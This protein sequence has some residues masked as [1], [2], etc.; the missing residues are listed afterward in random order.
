MH[1]DTEGFNTNILKAKDGK[2]ETFSLHLSSFFFETCSSAGLSKGRGG[3]L[4]LS[5]SN[6]YWMCSV[7][8]R[9][10]SG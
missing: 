7:F 10:Y 5:E 1:F 4:A 6:Y 8:I 3:Y 9:D 2:M